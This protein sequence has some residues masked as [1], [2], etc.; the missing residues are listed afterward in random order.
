MQEV[1]LV[2]H[3]ILALGIIGLV[4]IQRS[5]GGG[6][7]IGGGSG[8]MGNLATAQGTA[9]VLTKMTALF[10][11]GFFITSLTLAVLAGTG[12][13]ASTILD[14]T[15]PTAAERAIDEAPETPAETQKTAPQVPISE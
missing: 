6:L 1:V 9:S 4:L 10:G 13:T 7:G 5:E 12:D 15:A 8:G 14:K 2:I 3:I 11:A